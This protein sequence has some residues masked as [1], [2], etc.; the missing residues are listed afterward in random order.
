MGRSWRQAGSTCLPSAICHLLLHLYFLLQGQGQGQGR[1]GL[2]VF[3]PMSTSILIPWMPTHSLC[4]S[5]GGVGSV[6]GTYLVTVVIEY[7]LSYAVPSLTLPAAHNESC[8][9]SSI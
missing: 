7:I 3:I 9:L 4:A 6:S 1:A 2:S 8:V 5:S